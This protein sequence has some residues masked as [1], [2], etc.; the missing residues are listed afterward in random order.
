M[1][2]GNGSHFS[3]GQYPLLATD[4]SE[5][6]EPK[7]LFN[8]H[9]KQAK[10]NRALKKS[11]CPKRPVWQIWFQKIQVISFLMWKLDFPNAQFITGKGFTKICQ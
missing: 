7:R 3:S 9:F 8:S 4:A 11:K 2:L 5:P 1:S 10:E 6:P